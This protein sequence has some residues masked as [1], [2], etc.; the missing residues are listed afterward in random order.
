MLLNTRNNFDIKHINFVNKNY[1]ENPKEDMHNLSFMFLSDE[2][3]EKNALKLLDS[4][5]E[6]ENPIKGLMTRLFKKKGNSKLTKLLR[7]VDK[8]RLFRNFGLQGVDSEIET[9]VSIDKL[10]AKYRV[11]YYNK[12]YK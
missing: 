4:Y 2:K 6:Q 1:D 12:Y 7:R 9:T 10:Y 8:K 3:L 11:K 5:D